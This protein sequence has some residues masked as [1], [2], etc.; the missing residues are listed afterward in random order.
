MRRIDPSFIAR[1]YLTPHRHLFWR[2]ALA[3]RLK[4]LP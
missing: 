3:L 4:N 2:D 1:H